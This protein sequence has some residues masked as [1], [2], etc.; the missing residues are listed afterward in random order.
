[1]FS[2]VL[3]T[4]PSVCDT[5]EATENKGDEAVEQKDF[6]AEEAIRTPEEEINVRVVLR[7]NAEL[8]EENAY[9]KE[10]IANLEK[11][12]YGPKS[13]KTETILPNAEQIPMFDEAES[14]A[15]PAAAKEITVAEHKRIKRTRDELTK[16]LPRETVVCEGPKTCD[17]CGAPTE[18]IGQEKIREELVYVPA[19][20]YVREYVAEVV[21]CTECGKDESRDAALPDIEPCVILKGKA[22]EAMIPHSF[23]SPELLAHIAYEKYANAVPLYRQEKDFKAKGAVLS[24]TTMANWIIWSAEQWIKPIF[25][26]MKTELLSSSVI[27]A[28]ETVVQVLN[29]PGRKA[30]TDSRMWVYCNGKLN[31]KSAILFE[32]TP[33]RNGDNA[34]RFLGDYSGY[35]VCDGYDGYNKLKS[36]TRCGCW[37]HARR[38]FA[39]ALP[40][41]K[42]IPPD[43]AAVK[44]VEFCNRIFELERE[45]DGLCPEYAE[46]GSVTGWAKVREALDPEARKKQRQEKTKPVLDDFFAWLETVAPASKSALSSAVQ[47]AKNEKTYLYRFLEDGNIPVS[48]NRA[49]NAIRP[50]TI[51]RKNWLFSA[52]VKGACASAM[53]YSVIATAC[54]NGLA[55]EEYLT[56]LFSSSPGT[57]V[58][59]W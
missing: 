23:C 29:E 46:D 52:S 45:Y 32:Y 26:A 55:P 9:L 58:L 7:E 14:E 40:N 20:L 15:S 57:V 1:L 18:V 3:Q 17:V 51:G 37:A 56:R 47:Y 22:P 27:H 6:L 19:K 2:R 50:F 16:D 53:F 31:D 34:A 10:R 30:K 33:T 35:L 5:I 4:F 54:A 42:E 43:S 24:R 25:A 36:V 28:D 44:G 39:D 11:L 59:P 49:E 12:V 48:N 13:E 41:K 21:K 38:K 8:K